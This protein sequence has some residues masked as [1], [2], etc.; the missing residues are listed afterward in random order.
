MINL[1]ENTF[2][3]DAS[4]E[5]QLSEFILTNTHLSMGPQTKKFE[6]AFANWHELD[7]CIMF[8]SGSSANLAL[9]MALINLGRLRAG[10]QIGVSS[11]TWSTNVMPIIQLGLIPVL[12]DVETDGLNMCPNDLSEKISNLKAVFHTNILG[13]ENNIHDIQALCDLNGILLLEDNCEGLGCNSKG[14]R[15]GT[16]G[17]ASTASSF[18]GHHLSTIEGGYVFTNDPVLAAMLKVVRAHGW[19]RNLNESEK[20]LLGCSQVD[21]FEAS[22]TFEYLGFNLRPSDINA[23]SGLL[24]LPYLD[25]FNSIR[26]ERFAVFIE[27]CQSLLWSGSKVNPAFA[28]PIRCK[29]GEQKAAMIEFLDTSQ[30][31][32]RPLVSGSMGSQPFWLRKHGQRDYLK[33]ASDVDNLGLYVTN[34]PQLPQMKFEKLIQVLEQFND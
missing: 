3:Q 24:Q 22:Y 33:N 15:L 10:D 1:M 23:Y 27:R 7:F 6:Q 30:I 20:H 19:T 18:V 31:A 9:I 29:S 12:I 28:L 32:C 17:L 2:F 25:H 21:A 8:N 34:D 4:V 5:A 26:E 14:S 11:V 13:L 16:F